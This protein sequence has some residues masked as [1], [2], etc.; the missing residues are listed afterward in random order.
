[1]ASQAQ[2]N[3]QKWQNYLKTLPKGVQ[4]PPDVMKGYLQSRDY[5]NTYDNEA[6]QT[7][8]DIVLKKD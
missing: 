5:W 3:E 4:P 6:V 2:K 1:M 8:S 7:F